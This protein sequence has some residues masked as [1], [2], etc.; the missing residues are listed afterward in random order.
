MRLSVRPP[1]TGN[2]RAT[3]VTMLLTIDEWALLTSALNE[4]CH[5]IR[6]HDD[7]FRIRT[8]FSR[9]EACALLDRLHRVLSDATARAA[10]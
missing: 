4:L 7:E 10:D 2:D 8:G 3:S 6:I 5:G 9:D 1:G